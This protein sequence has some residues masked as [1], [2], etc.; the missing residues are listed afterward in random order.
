MSSYIFQSISIFFIV[1]FTY[2][3][4]FE[5]GKIFSESV[6]F[7]EL[8]KLSKKGFSK[9]ILTVKVNICTLFSRCF[10]DF[11]VY[12]WSSKA[13]V[14]SL[15]LH[16]LRKTIIKSTCLQSILIIATL[17]RRFIRQLFFKLITT[18]SSVYSGPLRK[19]VFFKMSCW[20]WQNHSC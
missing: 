3:I 19:D 10:K 12:S 17:S 1:H 15:L 6:N 20:Y 14:M 16:H 9:S 7:I 2:Q 4:G 8:S 5:Y 18:G 11:Q 13:Y